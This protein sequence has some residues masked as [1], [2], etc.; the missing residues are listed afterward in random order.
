MREFDDVE[1]FEYFGMDKFV[2]SYIAD[3]YK[4]EINFNLND[5]K[6]HCLD[7]ETDATGGYADIEKADKPIT[8]IGIG[9]G[10]HRVVF[11]YKE[12]YTPKNSK[13][14]IFVKCDDEID[15]LNRFL[16]FWNDD[17]VRPDIV[18]GWNIEG[19]DIPYI[20][21]RL[22]NQ[23]GM[24]AAE[25]LSPWGIL[26]EKETVIRG[27]PVKVFTPVGIAVL[28]YLQLY[29]K[30]TYNQQESYTLDHI[31]WV[32]VQKRKLDYS[33]YE[34]LQDMYNKDFG[35][36]IEYNIAD[37]D[38]VFDIDAKKRFIE[39]AVTMAYDAKVNYVDSLT[40]VRIWDVMIY[41]HLL[42]KDIII[43]K[44]MRGEARSVP[45]GYVKDPQI[46]R[47]ENVISVDFTSLY[48][49]LM[50]FLNIS[51]ETLVGFAEWGMAHL[52]KVLE[53]KFSNDHAVANGYGQAANGARFRNDKLGFL[54]E[55]VDIQ[56]AKRQEYKDKM[57]ELKKANPDD[58]LIDKFNNY[59]LA[60]KIQMNSLYGALANEYCRYYDY[61]LA[62]AITLTGQLAIR[63][64]E[65]R[66]NE[67]LNDYFKTTGDDYVIA[68]DT[69]SC[70][71]KLEKLG[72]ENRI[73]T[74]N[75]FAT[76]VI[77]PKIAEWMTDFQKLLNAYKDA[78]S[79]KLE[80]I[81]DRAIWKAKKMYMMNI[82]QFEGIAYKVPELKMMGIEAVKKVIPE[83]C[84]NALKEA[85]SLCL[86]SDER[87][88]QQYVLEFRKRF[89]ELSFDDI[90]FPRGVKGI[91][92][93]RDPVTSWKLGTPVH[94][95]A[96][97]V[98][99]NY[100]KANGLDTKF[101]LIFDRDKIKF[102][103]L[104]EP[105]PTKAAVIA[106]PRMMPKQLEIDD[107]IDRSLMFE[108]TFKAPLQSILQAIGWSIEERSVLVFP[109]DD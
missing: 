68:M 7:I 37:L 57:K 38:R 18:T 104:K 63:Y 94:V 46:G 8:L 103:Y 92:K 41:N 71:I 56:F 70:Y 109:E 99:N 49:R 45:G 72:T 34:N 47:H 95:K 58:K 35:K 73:E 101:P 108:K 61:R 39:L 20:V 27:R 30:F 31:A 14:H 50:I 54:P 60:K 10:K 83:V 26:I 21:N 3:E 81:S 59:Q 19:Y 79:M 96:S 102:A 98:Y 85:I 36:Y 5:I 97:I 12:H 52:D 74:L 44:S 86:N 48:P 32:E 62:S 33:E 80:A 9:Y 23:M 84:R 91:D 43:P 105:N 64:V 17:D 65:K 77:E 15:M 24:E 88:V 25:R 2:Y 22:R 16:D 11:G 87:S 40:S 107:H 100:L 4:G 69:D 93:Y 6:V 1:G 67:F 51:P 66:I 28:D 106:A 13:R 89:N 76:E 82:N 75:K 55:I 29:Q 53:G 78:L 90:A 42:A